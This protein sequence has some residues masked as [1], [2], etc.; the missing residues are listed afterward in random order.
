[1]FHQLAKYV[2]VNHPLQDTD[3]ERWPM[4]MVGNSQNRSPDAAQHVYLTFEAHQL[5]VIAQHPPPKSS[6]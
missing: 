1:M 4:G 6:L 5:P 2:W 3:I